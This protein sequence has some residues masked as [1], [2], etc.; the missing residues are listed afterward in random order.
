MATEAGYV[1]NYNE[2]MGALEWAREFIHRA[3]RV[4]SNLDDGTWPK[5]TTKY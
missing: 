5:I 2:A 3:D 4:L 1:I